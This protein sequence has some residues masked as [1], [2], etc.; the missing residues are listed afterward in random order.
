MRGQCYSYGRCLLE[1]REPHIKLR[2]IKTKEERMNHVTVYEEYNVETDYIG[3]PIA[4][5]IHFKNRDG[6]IYSLTVYD[7]RTYCIT[8]PAHREYKRVSAQG[9]EFNDETFDKIDPG[10][11]LW[12]TAQLQ[13]HYEL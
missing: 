4:C 11:R 9:L 13:Q 7:N 2:Y 1:I 12:L 5:D 8:Y 3:K 10:F 6:D